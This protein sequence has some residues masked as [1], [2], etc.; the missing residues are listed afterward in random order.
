MVT[1]SSCPGPSATKPEG[2]VGDGVR[3]SE[4]EKREH[5]ERVREKEF[6]WGPS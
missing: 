4:G 1:F 3:R 6:G 2:G 5:E